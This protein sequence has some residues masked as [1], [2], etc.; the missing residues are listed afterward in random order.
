[1]RYTLS[2]V[3]G[4]R[5]GSS[6]ILKRKDRP[7]APET[8]TKG[9][10]SLRTA[11]RCQSAEWHVGLSCQ[12]GTGRLHIACASQ[13]KPICRL[14]LT[15]FDLCS[16]TIAAVTTTR[17]GWAARPG[18]RPA[19]GSFR[20]PP[21][22]PGPT[23]PCLSRPSAGT[24]RDATVRTW[25]ERDAR[26]GRGGPGIPVPPRA[27]RDPP[28]EERPSPVPTRA[29]RS[30]VFACVGAYSVHCTPLRPCQFPSTLHT[31][32]RYQ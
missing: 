1:M 21:L 9:Q 13:T 23:R 29:T 32:Y 26:Q 25:E 8:L 27:S 14:L 18:R 15:M 20:H 5:E 31:L 6:P 10:D 2:P 3:T 19:P 22:H 16:L 24:S 17:V 4:E 28:E 30:L 12:H 7:E 11:N